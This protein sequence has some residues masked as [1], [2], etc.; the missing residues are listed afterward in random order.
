VNDDPAF[1]PS[2]AFF[3]EVVPTEESVLLAAVDVAVD[4]R[5][6]SRR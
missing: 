2:R 4:R 5:Y 6:A 3:V 1:R